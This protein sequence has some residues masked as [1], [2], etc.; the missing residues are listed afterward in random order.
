M[1]AT[2]LQ[3]ALEELKKQSYV[4]EDRLQASCSPYNRTHCAHVESHGA[5]RLSC[6]CVDVQESLKQCCACL[7]MSIRHVRAI[8]DQLKRIELAVA[9]AKRAV[10]SVQEGVSKHSAFR[11]L[12]AIDAMVGRR[13]HFDIRLDQ[14]D[15]AR[16]AAAL[17]SDQP[18]GMRS[19]SGIDELIRQC[20]PSYPRNTSPFPPPFPPPCSPTP[21]FSR[22]C[23]GRCIRPGVNP[24]LGGTCVGVG[25]WWASTRTRH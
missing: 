24:C 11:A 18:H 5:A 4:D 10:Q 6:E 22:A 2:E 9:R 25:V 7:Q 21:L 23:R 14:K 1:N 13:L 20:V 8:G 12:P 16:A 17:S 3:A 15:V 19:T